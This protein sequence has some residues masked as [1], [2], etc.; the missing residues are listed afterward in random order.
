VSAPS[1]T[2]TTPRSLLTPTTTANDEQHQQQ[3][4]EEG[5]LPLPP[6]ARA[7]TEDSVTSSASSSSSSRRSSLDLSAVGQALSRLL[8]P[9]ER[10]GSKGGGRG[11]KTGKEGEEEHQQQEQEQEPAEDTAAAPTPTTIQTPTSFT[12]GSALSAL[13]GPVAGGTGRSTDALVQDKRAAKLEAQLTSLR[14][15]YARLQARRIE[16]AVSLEEVIVC[17]VCGVGGMMVFI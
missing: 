3:Q 7:A 13:T 17:C 16:V 15:Q 8:L 11:S 4:Q 14:A 1:P 5:S 12:R 10:K 9:T 2:T 6:R